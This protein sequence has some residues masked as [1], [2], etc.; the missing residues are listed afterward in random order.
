MILKPLKDTFIVSKFPYHTM[1][2]RFAYRHKLSTNDPLPI[3][4]TNSRDKGLAI[5]K[6]E[7]QGARLTSIKNF[8]I[9]K[10]LIRI[11]KKKSP[12]LFSTTCS[13]I[14]KLDLPLPNHPS[15]SQRE[16]M[17]SW[18]FFAELVIIATG[19]MHCFPYNLKNKNSLP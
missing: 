13:K 2:T 19:V 3:C 7:L 10:I 6:D 4:C 9:K 17:R 12:Q 1:T 16:T 8:M 18:L 14:W 15:L 11:Y 5:E